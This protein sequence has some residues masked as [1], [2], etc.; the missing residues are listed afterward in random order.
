[1]S[2]N[3]FQHHLRSCPV[4][5]APVHRPDIPVQSHDIDV[6]DGI[7]HLLNSRKGRKSPG[8]DLEITEGILPP[9][10]I[11]I[12]IGAIAREKE[13][14]RIQAFFVQTLDDKFIGHH[15]DPDKTVPGCKL[16]SVSAVRSERNKTVTPRDHHIAA[17]K[18]FR[19]PFNGAC[20]HYRPVRSIKGDSR[21]GQRPGSGQQ[22]SGKG[23][24]GRHRKA[25]VIIVP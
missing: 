17:V 10:R 4:C 15:P 8:N 1:M 13:K 9:V 16:H 6:P 11:E 19:R 20:R 25:Q 24:Q 18:T 3:D 14:A 23:R 22:K 2:V 21:A 5:K 12:R 7:H